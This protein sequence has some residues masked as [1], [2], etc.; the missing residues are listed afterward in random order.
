LIR[1]IL[2]FYSDNNNNNNKI[3]VTLLGSLMK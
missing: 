3:R 1:F 2:Q